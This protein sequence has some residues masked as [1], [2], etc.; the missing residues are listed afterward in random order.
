MSK[1]D[2]LY[3]PEGDVS[4]KTT[5]H[6]LKGMEAKETTFHYLK[7]M[8][9]TSVPEGDGFDDGLDLLHGGDPLAGPVEPQVREGN[10]L[11]YLKNWQISI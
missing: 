8:T 9:S 10:R 1:G 7:G 5:Y 6:Y 2:D 4:K 11:E 3:V